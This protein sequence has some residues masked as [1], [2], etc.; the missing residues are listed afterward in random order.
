MLAGARVPVYG[1]GSS[2]RDFTYV[3]DI[4]DGLIAAMDADV[5]FGLFNLGAG[6][7]VSVLEV[8]KLLESSLGVRADIE[9]LPAQVGDVPQTWAD[10]SAARE[11]FGYAPQFRLEEGIA[12]FVAWLKEGR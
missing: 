8:V 6:R 5:G 3:D 12:R 1:D 11:A 4:V 9:W 10:V 7:Q 2:L